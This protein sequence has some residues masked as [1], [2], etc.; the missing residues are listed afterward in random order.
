MATDTIRCKSGIG[1]KCECKD[2]EDYAVHVR[3]PHEF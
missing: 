3:A 1:D 2:D